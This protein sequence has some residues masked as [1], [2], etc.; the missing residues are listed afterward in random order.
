MLLC[1]TIL[2]AEQGRLA[3]AEASR[4]EAKLIPV[5][6]DTS[7]IQ[8]MTLADTVLA[9]HTGQ[10]A[11]APAS[12]QWLTFNEP[13]SCVQPLFAGMTY[14]AMPDEE[15]FAE[16]VSNLRRVAETAPFLNAVAD[17]LDGLHT[18]DADLLRQTADRLDGM[19][20]RLLAAQTRLEWSEL[21]DNRE[22][23]PWCIETFEWA[24]AGPWL[25]R[26]RH[27]ARSL[28]VRIPA[29]RKTGLL[30]NR[31]SQIVRLL[32]EGLSNADIAS[33]LFLSQRTVETHL[34]NSYAKLGL[35]SRIAL[36]RWAA[37]N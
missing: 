1:R 11:D 5:A 10:P 2:L 15:K 35:N 31:E 36:A 16:T 28:G 14:L 7:L 37:E 34:R 20:A 27:H 17:R 29:A 25:E 4:A 23:I 30:S 12:T 19:G 8:L 13:L 24:G 33:R 21:T 26:C 3:E 32:G 18:A 9:T 22:S 6:Q